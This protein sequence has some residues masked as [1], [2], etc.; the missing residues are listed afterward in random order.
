MLQTIT[1]CVW[2]TAELFEMDVAQTGDAM[3]IV[4]ENF[5]PQVITRTGATSFVKSAFGFDESTNGEKVY[6]PYFKFAD[7]AVTLD[8]NQTDKGNTSRN[9]CNFSKLFYK[10]LCWYAS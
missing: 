7:N 4:H 6:Q 5:T 10:C 9:L 1:S 8:I 2:E 3:I